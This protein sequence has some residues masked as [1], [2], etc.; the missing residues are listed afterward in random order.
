MNN[1]IFKGHAISICAGPHGNRSR[2]VF[3]VCI[4]RKR[5]DLV[6]SCRV[7]VYNAARLKESKAPFVMEAAMAKLKVQFVIGAYFPCSSFD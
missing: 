7:L 5:I 4:G 2:E 6:G 3:R 1:C